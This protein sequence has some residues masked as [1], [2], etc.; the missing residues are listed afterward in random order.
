MIQAEIDHF[1]QEHC[2]VEPALTTK[3]AG[4]RIDIHG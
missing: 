4:V 3:F 2:A 1:C